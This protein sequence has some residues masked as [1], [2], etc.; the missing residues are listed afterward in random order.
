MALD[1][2][3]LLHGISTGGLSELPNPYLRESKLLH[4]AW[5]Q[6]QKKQH[7]AMEKA[8]G[9]KGIVLLEGDITALPQRVHKKAKAKKR[10]R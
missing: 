6:Y 4:A 1:F 5:A 8:S 9:C 2:S 3:K 7:E 10:K